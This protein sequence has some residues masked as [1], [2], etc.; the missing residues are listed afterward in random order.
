MH[1]SFPAFIVKLFSY[2]SFASL[3]FFIFLDVTSLPSLVSWYA[4]LKCFFLVQYIFLY[5]YHSSGL[6]R[7]LTQRIPGC[8]CYLGYLSMGVWWWSKSFIDAQ[9]LTCCQMG[10][11]CGVGVDCNSHGFVCFKLFSSLVHIFIWINSIKMFLMEVP[12]FFPFLYLL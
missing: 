2:L 1:F 7:R 9:E 4:T 5:C 10:W 12:W 11:W 8:W 3:K 6:M